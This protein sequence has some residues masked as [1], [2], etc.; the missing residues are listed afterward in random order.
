MSDDQELRA[1]QTGR[2]YDHV[3]PEV[4]LH[5]AAT[6]YMA[7]VIW[8]IQLVHYPMFE[9]LDRTNFLRSHLFHTSA[10]TF[11]VLPAMLLEL[12]MAIYILWIRGHGNWPAV[13]GLALVLF[14]WLV[15]FLIMVP[16]H[17]R[18]GSEGF[19]P[20]VLRALIQWN[21]LRTAAWSTRA[22]IAAFWL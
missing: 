12:A 17:E 3:M 1:L 14:L 2:R 4:T 20:E 7:G 10:I 6:W 22:V 19:Q 18:L 21:W 16:L 15:T 8:L 9:Y 11:V 5:N 13:A